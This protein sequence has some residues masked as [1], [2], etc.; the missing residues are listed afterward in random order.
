MKRGLMKGGGL[1]VSL[2]VIV[3]VTGQAV[4]YAY[5]DTGYDRAD[6][7]NDYP[8]VR[9]TTRRVW[10]H[11]DSR[12]L[13]VSFI[14][15]EKLDFP[16][17]YWLMRVK[18]DT[19][20]DRSFDVIMKFWDLDMSGSG[21]IARNRERRGE[22]VDGRLNL[23]SHGASCTVRSSQFMLRKQVRW[24]LISPAL[25]GGDIEYAPNVGYYS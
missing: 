4:A 8:D 1:L 7:D 21:C 18:L 13:R 22:R 15:E 17:A 6:R 23:R 24:K 11:N 9:R 20:G 19:R 10:T 25:H 16:A 5:E 12:F 2:V 3:L 14:G